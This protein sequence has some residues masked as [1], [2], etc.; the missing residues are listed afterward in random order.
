MSTDEAL[1]V[2][3]HDMARSNYDEATVTGIDQ[4]KQAV[5]MR[6]LTVIG[7]VFRNVTLG[8]INF[9]AMATKTNIPALINAAN[10]TTIKSTPGITSII[11]YSSVYDTETRVVDVSFAAQTIYGQLTI[12]N[13]P[14][15]MI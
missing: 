12:S 1:N 15:R 10:K 7:E 6:L 4:I 9:K 5:K 3:S 2:I 11:S 14:Q 8:N 13:F